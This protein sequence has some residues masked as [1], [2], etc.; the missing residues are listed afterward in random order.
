[1]IFVLTL[2]YNIE[3]LHSLVM[4]AG[5]IM[6]SMGEAFFGWLMRMEALN[7]LVKGGCH[8]FLKRYPGRV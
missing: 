4:G 2:I 8:C 3:T 6:Y 5:R 1:M 7:P